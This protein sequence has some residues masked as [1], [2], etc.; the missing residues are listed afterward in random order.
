MR[1]KVQQGRRKATCKR[2]EN[3]VEGG[4]VLAAKSGQTAKSS[5]SKKMNVGLSAVTWQRLGTEFISKTFGKIDHFICK[6]L[7]NMSAK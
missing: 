7:V 5:I 4:K 2:V 6:I 1:I 3:V